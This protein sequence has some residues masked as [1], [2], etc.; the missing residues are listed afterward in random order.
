VA[1]TIATS[2]HHVG[3]HAALLVG[4]VIRQLPVRHGRQ[5][6]RVEQRPDP[7][8]HPGR[9]NAGDWADI[10]QQIVKA[11]PQR[12]WQLSG[13]RLDG[14]KRIIP[15]VVVVQNYNAGASAWFQLD[16]E[17]TSGG[18]TYRVQDIYHIQYR[19]GLSPFNLPGMWATMC[20][21]YAHNFLQGWDLYGGGGKIGHWDLLG[22]NSPPGNMSDTS[23]FYRCGST[24]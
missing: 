10:A 18:A 3:F 9:N 2:C 14:A 16:R 12:I 5:P 4:A 13:S 19:T 23:S 24:G 17:F 7:D 22:D 15:S 11:N 21:E 8:D 6:R 20:H 1:R